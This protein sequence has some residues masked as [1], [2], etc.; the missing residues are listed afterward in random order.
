MT[1][2]FGASYSGGAG[3]TSLLDRAVNN[4]SDTAHGFVPGLLHIGGG[5]GHDAGSLITG[6]T[7]GLL[8]PGI[9]KQMAQG[10]VQNSF[11][12]PLL[13]GHP[14]EALHRASERPF[15]ALMDSTLAFPA[16]TGVAK[17]AASTG[18]LLGHEDLLNWGTKAQ[19]LVKAPDE[20]AAGIKN[21][22]QNIAN[23]LLADGNLPLYRD[24][25]PAQFD[26]DGQKLLTRE[27]DPFST[28]GMKNYGDDIYLRQSKRTLPIGPAA[29]TE[30]NASGLQAMEDW[31]QNSAFSNPQGMLGEDGFK[32]LTSY[33][34]QN[35]L[36]ASAGD[37]LFGFMNKSQKVNDILRKTAFNPETRIGRHITRAQTNDARTEY[38]QNYLAL[39]K[40]LG[41]LRDEMKQNPEFANLDDAGLNNIIAHR[42]ALDSMEIQPHDLQAVANDLNPNATLGM[43]QNPDELLNLTP[44]EARARPAG[45]G[46][47]PGDGHA[48][49]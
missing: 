35:P 25:L 9:G 13:T 26:V 14:M 45:A 24:A 6:H 12:P 41:A 7:D 36:L 17:A 42:H 37:S 21:I 48:A 28:G 32:N 22:Q 2:S 11:L 49:R 4:L 8:L 30:N 39:Q 19:G 29:A 18:S 27:W 16:F 15:D 10:F 38:D 43:F 34:A 1:L 33:R 47:A 46:A 5:I 3:K 31:K 23:P 40:N 20:L 44:A